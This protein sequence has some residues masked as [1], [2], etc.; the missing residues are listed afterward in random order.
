MKNYSE[1]KDNYESI[2]SDIKSAILENYVNNIDYN[3]D[4]QLTVVIHDIDIT[5]AIQSINCITDLTVDEL[6][7]NA[8]FLAEK[9]LSHNTNFDLFVEDDGEL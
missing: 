4:E 9:I 6:D 3:P 1:I 5:N 8:Q 2:Q 7:Y